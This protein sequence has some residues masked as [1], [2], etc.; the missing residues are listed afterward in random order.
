MIRKTSNAYKL[1]KKNIGLLTLIQQATDISPSRLV[2][3]F[4]KNIPDQELFIKKKTKD[5][6]W[7]TE[8]LS[9]ESAYKYYKRASNAYLKKIEENPNYHSLMDFFKENYLTKD[10]FGPGQDFYEL[11]KA[12]FYEEAGLKRFIREAF[13]KTFPITPDMSPKERAIRNQKLGKISTQH[14]IGD[15]TNYDYF[16]QAPGF[17]MKRVEEAIRMIELYVAHLL[18][19]KDIWLRTMNLLSNQRLEERLI[20]KE[21]K[22]KQT[23][24]VRKI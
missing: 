16:Q 10:Y 12:Y 18:N 23:V 8:P 4:L 17:M 13:I 9:P 2:I 22:F 14:W 24:K 20:P 11:R 1:I 21:E 15:I 7:T 6:F 5:E 3:L 19:E